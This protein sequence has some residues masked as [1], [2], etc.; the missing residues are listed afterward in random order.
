MPLAGFEPGSLILGLLRCLLRHA[1]SVHRNLSYIKVIKQ[2]FFV[3]AMVNGPAEF[4]R[5][6]TS[7]K[8]SADLHPE[9]VNFPY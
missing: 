4:F 8:K 6:K 1:A 7:C 9:Q 2:V 5:G 3:F